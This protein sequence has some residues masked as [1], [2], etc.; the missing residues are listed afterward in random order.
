MALHEWTPC[1]TIT[2][3]LVTRQLEVRLAA[4]VGRFRWMFAVVKD[5][6]ISTDSL[7]GNQEGVLRHVACSVDLSFMIDLLNHLNLGCTDKH[8]WM[9]AH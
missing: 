3:G 1:Q 2:L 9:A 5:V 8:D 7:G 6:N 4:V